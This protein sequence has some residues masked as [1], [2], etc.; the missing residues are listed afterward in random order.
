MKKTNLLAILTLAATPAFLQA[1]TTSYSDIVGYQKISVPTNASTAAFP[2]LNPDLLKT[3][4][5]GLSGSVL[6][7]SGQSNIGSL[8]SSGV[9]YYLEVYSGTLKGD[10]FDVDTAAT[11][12]SANGTV[13]LASSSANNTFPLGSIGTNLNGATVALRKHV[14]LDQISAGASP[15]LL[16][17]N[18]STSADQVQLFNPSNR[19]YTTYYL[20][21]DGTNW[22][23]SGA[24]TN[25]FNN[26]VIAPGTGVFIQKRT[27]P[28]EI[29]SVGSVRQ[30]D[31]AR[32]YQTGLQLLAMPY[33]INSTAQ[34]FGGTRANGWT[35]NNIVTSAD[36][37]QIFNPSNRTYTTYYLRG[38]GVNW[39]LSGAT[40]DEASNFEMLK[41]ANAFFVRRRAATSNNIIVNPIPN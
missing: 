37:I 10:R 27:T 30:N 35:G 29:T 7:L 22:R 12:S 33:P 39:R 41:S 15:A 20:R 23:L 18:L 6:S 36:Q 8:L 19:T 25:G 3:S 17:N 34:N 31:F 32:P 5:S 2:M 11:I 4:A 28:T 40:T 14:T 38:D 16:G 13:T 9:P 21:A 26:V 1:Q 24:T